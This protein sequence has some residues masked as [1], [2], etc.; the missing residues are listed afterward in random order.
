MKE[1]PIST[2]GIRTPSSSFNAKWTGTTVTELLLV[3]LVA[4]MVTALLQFHWKRRRLYKMAAK[5][6][7]PPSFPF[8]GSAHLFAGST[9]SKPFLFCFSKTIAERESSDSIDSIRRVTLRYISEKSCLINGHFRYLFN[10]KTKVKRITQE[11]VIFE[12]F[13][14]FV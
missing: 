7:G 9:F 4:I 8:I 13:E 11:G 10:T 5:I 1:I 2:I 6:P 12:T 14:A 3:S